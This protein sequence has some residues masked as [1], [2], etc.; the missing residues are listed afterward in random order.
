M[1]TPSPATS[2]LPRLYDEEGDRLMETD[3]RS[4]R[5]IIVPS[6]DPRI[7]STD[8]DRIRIEWGQHLLADL[9]G[10]RYRSVV[11]GVNQEDNSGGIISQLADL[12]PTSQWTAESI[13]GYVK[14]FAETAKDDDVFVLKFDMDAVEVLGL[15]RPPNRDYFTVRDLEI[16]FRKISQMLERRWDR[17]P[18]AAVSFLAAKSN[19]LVDEDGEEPSFETVLRTMYDAGYRGDVYPALHMWEL[20][21]TGVFATYPFPDSLKVMR[22]GGF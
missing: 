1:S 18:C 15:M 17:L 11:C 14:T 4:N 5:V 10:H 20:H 13:T 19:H 2:R 6:G 16:G 22:A 3:R 21:P 12:L 7:A 9:L 8:R